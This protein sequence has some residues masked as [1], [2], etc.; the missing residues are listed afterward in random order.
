MSESLTEKQE[1]VLKF[2]EEFQMAYGKSPTLREMREHFGV[3]SDNSIL[4]HLKALEE[5]GHIQKDDTPRG[6]QLLSSI[7]EKLDMA[8]ESVKLP[9]LGFVPAGGP[10]MTDEYINGYMTV[11]EE[12]AKNSSDFF[13]LNVTG[14]SMIDAG[15]FEGDLVVVNGKKEPKDGDIVVALVDNGNTLKRFIKKSG[16]VYLKAENKDYKDIYPEDELLVQGV[17]TALIRQYGG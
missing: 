17:V 9:V 2:I 15:I 12:L 4:K 11:G 3:S 5:K 1:A 16:K 14:N 13:L 7:R 6:I 10:V 8:V